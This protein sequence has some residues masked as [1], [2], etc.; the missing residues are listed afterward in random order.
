MTR[1]QSQVGILALVTVLLGCGEG[2]PS[3]SG[4]VTYDGNPVEKGTISVVPV[5]GGGSPAGGVIRDGSYQIEKVSLGKHLVSFSA[6]S[7]PAEQPTSNKSVRAVET[8]P[9][10]AVGNGQEVEIVAGAQTMN[11]DLKPPR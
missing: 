2:T 11:F 10:D 1:N 6:K 5:G 3:V 7:L 9:P 4:Q 8:I